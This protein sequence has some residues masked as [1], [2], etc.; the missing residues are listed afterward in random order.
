MSIIRAPRPESNFYLLDKSIIEDGRL[1]WAARGLLVYLLGK[2]DHWQV[3]VAHL[4]KET[5]GSSKPTGRDGVY[6]LLEELIQ[7]GYIIREQAR[8]E[9]GKLGETNY[10]VSER[11]LTDSPLPAEPDTA[12][13]YTA[14]PTQVSIEDKQE[15]I[16]PIT[17]GA[18]APID[19]G[20]E[21][22]WKVYPKREGANPKNKAHSAWKARLREGVTPEQMLAGV[23]RYAEYCQKTDRIKTS[24]VMQAVRF[25]GTERAFE[26]DWAASPVKNQKT[27]SRHHGLDQIDYGSGSTDTVIIGGF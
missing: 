12:E 19:D 2:P 9:D 16:E 17:H 8:R 27:Q 13:P 25:F 22:A 18:S 26:N 6:A 3:S 11:P 24:Y 20:F 1:S 4:R 7:A 14:N 21:Q 10:I 23:M 5:A 15:P